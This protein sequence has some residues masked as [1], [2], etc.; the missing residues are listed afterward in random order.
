MQNPTSEIKKYQHI[1]FDLDHTIW[2]FDKNA[3][4]TLYEL[5]DIYRL[6]EIGLPSPTVFIETYT[7]NN[8]Q[9]WAEYHTGKI[10]KTELRETRFRRTFLELGLRPD[11]IPLQFEDDYV[12]LCPTKTNLFP[13]AHETLQYLQSK[14][15]LHLISNGFKEASTLKIGNTNIGGYF[16][17]VIISEV[18]GYNKP[19]KAIFE[20]ALNLAGTT[21]NESLM[22]GDSLE[23][24]IYGALNFGMDAIYFNPFNVPKPDDVPLQITHL[25]EL[26]LLL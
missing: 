22:I 10:T 25:K 15:T 6:N 3:E 23:A 8:H 11:V 7:R 20:H 16:E 18:V 13:H 24:D 9:L 19:D 26:T 4:E 5:Y 1:F 14:Y 17:H 21:K 2:D 12:K